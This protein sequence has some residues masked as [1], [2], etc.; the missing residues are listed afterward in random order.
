MRYQGKC[1]KAGSCNC[2][3]TDCVLARAT[4]FSS[5]KHCNKHTNELYGCHMSC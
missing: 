1:D 2:G 4:N 5:I 3:C